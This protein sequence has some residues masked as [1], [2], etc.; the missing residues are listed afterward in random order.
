[1]LYSQ[2]ITV[3]AF[4]GYSRQLRCPIEEGKSACNLLYSFDQLA[5]NYSSNL[6]TVS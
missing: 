5:V 3:I 1:M 2:V 4:D 6:P